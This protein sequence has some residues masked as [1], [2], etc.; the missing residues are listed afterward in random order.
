MAQ[1]RK[2]AGT[3]ETYSGMVVKLGEF[4]YTTVGGG[5]EGNR[6]QLEP[7]D[8]TVDN[9]IPEIDDGIIGNGNGNDSNTSSFVYLEDYDVGTTDGILNVVDAN[10]W[11]QNGRQDIAQQIIGFITSN[12]YPPNRPTQGGQA[13]NQ[14]NNQQNQQGGGMSENN[15]NNGNNPGGNVGGNTGNNTGGGGG[16]Y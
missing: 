6:Q 15:E 7:M 10:Y 12:D 8:T 13:G 5:I 2:I 1:E 3:S 9:T 4:E 14:N 16:A 11:N